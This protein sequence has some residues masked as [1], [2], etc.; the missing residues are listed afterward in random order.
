MHANNKRIYNG[1]TELNLFKNE[2]NLLL[3]TCLKS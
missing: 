3:F 1:S 2:K